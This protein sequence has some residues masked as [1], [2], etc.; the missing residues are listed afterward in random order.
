MTC[1]FIRR[2]EDTEND[3]VRQEGKNAKNGKKVAVCQ[4]KREA[5]GETEPANILIFDFQFPELWE[6]KCLLF[7]LP[8][9]WYL[10]WQPKRAKMPPT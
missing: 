1:V 2:D 8:S 6:N 4:S 3:Q 7:K 5:S 10:L 9:L